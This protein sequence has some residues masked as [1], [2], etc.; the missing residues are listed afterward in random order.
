MRS[1]DEWIEQ[2]RPMFDTTNETILEEISQRAFFRGFLAA[3]EAV[4]IAKQ[5]GER[6]KTDLLELGLE[7]YDTL[8]E[9]GPW[10]REAMLEVRE[11]LMQKTF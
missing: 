1:F 4:N 8:H 6:G 3:L 9:L 2:Y 10:D 11:K 5:N 7:V